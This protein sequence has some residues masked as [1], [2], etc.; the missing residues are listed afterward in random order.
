MNRLMLPL[1]A[2]VLG[3]GLTFTVRADE[4]SEGAAIVDKAIKA[5]GG[6]A[7]VAG[8]HN[9][10]YKFKGQ[11]TEGGGNV[12]L[13]GTISVRGQDHYRVELEISKG[14][15]NMQIL[16]V[17]NGDQA[18]ISQMG[19]VQDAPKEVV[20]ALRQA[21]LAGR[22]ATLLSLLKDK[23]TQLSPLGEVKVNDKTTLG[24]KVARKDFKEFDLYF[25][26]ESGLIVKC[27]TKFMGPG[28]QE[29]DFEYVFSEPKEH[30]GLKHFSKML[31]NHKSENKTIVEFELV[32]LKA[33][34]KLEDG[35]FARP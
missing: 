33:D 26:K 2:A 10:V 23:D 1:A 21:F 8:L 31:L 9:A 20:S 27:E 15:Q 3:L 7:K 35:L 25:D 18:W 29:V 17:M 5:V 30:G 16:L 22:A 19:Q 14:G 6:E 24:L 34:Q 12:E 32:E 4:K 13:Q 28:N 11:V